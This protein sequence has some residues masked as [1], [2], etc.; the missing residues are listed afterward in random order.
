MYSLQQ[1]HLSLVAPLHF[2]CCAPAKYFEKER[3]VEIRTRD[4][5]AQLIPNPQSSPSILCFILGTTQSSEIQASL[6][7]TV[8]G[9]LRA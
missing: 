3:T 1:T 6:S 4:E 2:L 9:F 7:Y 5:T 8:F